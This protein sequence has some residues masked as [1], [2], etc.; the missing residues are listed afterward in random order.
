VLHAG[1][2]PTCAPSSRAS[3]A[4]ETRMSCTWADRQAA[5]LL[6]PHLGALTA[7]IRRCTAAGSTWRWWRRPTA[8]CT[9]TWT[10]ARSRVVPAPGT[11]TW[12]TP[13]RL[14]ST[15]RC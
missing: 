4:P 15:T 6:Q 2:S 13:P 5:D 1:R 14:P 9:C 3:T 12:A 11:A 8:P 7:P 10:A